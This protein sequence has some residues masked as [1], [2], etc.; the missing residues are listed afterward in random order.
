MYTMRIFAALAV[1]LAACGGDDG[2]DDAP[3]CGDGATG[4]L[5]AGG[6]FAVTDAADG[7]LV[8]AAIHAQAATTSPGEVSIACRDA[9]VPDGYV[10]LGPAVAFGPDLAWSD[11]PFELT[12]PYDATLLPAGAARRHVRIAAVR[13]KGDTSPFFPPL[14]NRQIDDAVPEAARVTFRAG[15]LTTYQVVAAADA[16]Q[17]VT[18]RFAYRALV[19]ISM[20]GNPAM[21]IALAHPDQFDSFADLGGEPGASVRYMLTMVRDYLFG[22]F[23]T[24]ADEAAGH[25]A[26]GEM[27][28]E[29]QRASYADQFEITSDFEHMLYQEGSG[30]GLTLKRGLY[31]KGVRDMARALGNPAMFNPEHPY[32]PPGVDPEFL[33]TPAAERCANPIVLEDFFDRE[34]NPDGSRPVITF[35]DGN[36][37][38][39]GLGYGVWDPAIDATDPFELGLAVEVG[40][41]NGRRDAGE[42]V[43]GN[44]YEPYEDVGADGLASA[45]E[46]GYDAATNPDPNGDDW[47]YQRNPRGTEGNLDHDAGEPYDDFGLDGV[48]G[49]CQ[50]GDTPP[51]GIAGCYDYGEGD[52]AWTLSPNIEHWYTADITT[53]LAGMTDAERR[54]MNMWFDAGIR[55]FLNTS[56]A[57]N[58]GAGAISG[59]HGLPIDIY[60]GFQI[61]SN[62]QSETQYDFTEIDWSELPKNMYVRYGNPDATPQQIELGD[63]RHVG[64]AVQI[65]NRATT[66]F[67]WLDKHFPEGDRDDEMGSGELI[68]DLVFLSPTTGRESP[69]GLFLP[70]GYNKPENAA[71]RYPVIFFLHG[72]G[73]E[74]A[75]LVDLSAIFE[76]YMQ[77][78]ALDRE[79]RF[80]KFIIVY[81]DGRCRPGTD[82]VPVDPVGDRCEQGTFYRDAV[83]G[84]PAQMETNLLELADYI[85]ATY[86]T[87]QPADVSYVP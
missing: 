21:S 84:G 74:P 26:I 73:Q 42:P 83:L 60:D 53:L 80:Q 44:A 31:M 40:T 43:I 52:G 75:D 10:A 47:H 20:G 5:A 41:P 28:L 33:E 35:C 69:Y 22:G 29:R 81:V 86:R 19:G 68:D 77:P 14:A 24:A 50:H 39:G 4:A 8:G 71:K 11:R 15:E 16:G 48:D 18:E 78:S 25:G 58:G 63:G 9:I 55:D 2:G 85:D 1:T 38:E 79:A 12:L 23:C 51:V 7:D 45:A 56:V 32:A 66:A 30:V 49:T 61:L 37:S 17:P 57:A 87:K 27:C 72:Y 62:A 54:H 70:P 65:I 67:A 6:T 46:P 34:F 3:S 13:S 59:L 36:D 82:G 64:T 76:I